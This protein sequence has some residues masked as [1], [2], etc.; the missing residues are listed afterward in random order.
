MPKYTLLD[1]PLNVGENPINLDMDKFTIRLERGNFTHKPQ[2]SSEDLVKLRDEVNKLAVSGDV[3][4]IAEYEVDDKG[5]YLI[6]GFD[7]PLVGGMITLETPASFSVVD[8]TMRGNNNIP[9]KYTLLAVEA[10]QGET[11]FNMDNEK[12]MA[13]FTDRVRKGTFS[14][15]PDF[16]SENLVE[17]LQTVSLMG[18]ERKYFK[19][20]AEYKEIDKNNYMLYGI[21]NPITGEMMPFKTPVSF[22]VDNGFIETKTSNIYKKVANQNSSTGSNEKAQIVLKPQNPGE[23]AATFE[24]N[25]AGT[26]ISSQDS[27]KEHSED[28]SK[29]TVVENQKQQPSEQVSPLKPVVPPEQPAKNVSSNNSPLKLPQ[30]SKKINVLDYL[31][32]MITNKTQATKNKSTV[33][34]NDSKDDD[35]N[36]TPSPRVGK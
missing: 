16:V 9:S 22:S 12:K 29:K 26:G 20:I 24:K 1:V 18:H 28:Q 7:N 14:H 19:V 5:N 11:W 6:F 13:E 30:Q 15:N 27:V 35:N 34:K 33:A 17:L 2:F 8:E 4:V 32:E 31:K 10:I 25:D 36:Q 21:T 3:H 23:R